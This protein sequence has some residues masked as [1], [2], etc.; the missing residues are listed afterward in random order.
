MNS[1]EIY[2]ISAKNFFQKV[3]IFT[4]S[5]NF[6]LEEKNSL[7]ADQNSLY[8]FNSGERELFSSRMEFWRKDKK[9][10]ISDKKYLAKIPRITVE[11]IANRW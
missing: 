6:I 3:R 5:Q 8:V 11:F 1:T 7:L 2:S 4:L 9:F 10:S